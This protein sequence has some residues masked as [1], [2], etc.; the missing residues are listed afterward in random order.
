MPIRYA[1]KMTSLDTMQSRRE[2]RFLTCLNASMD[3]WWVVWIISHE[4]VPKEIYNCSSDLFVCSYI[5]F[6]QDLILLGYKLKQNKFSITLS[7]DPHQHQRNLLN[8]VIERK[9]S[10]NESYPMLVHF[11]INVIIFKKQNF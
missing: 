1:H 10:F 9:S 8:P 3:G 6:H 7:E 4:N 2:M 11:C 5:Y